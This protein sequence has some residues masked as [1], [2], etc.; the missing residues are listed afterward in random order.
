VQRWLTE[1]LF[2]TTK[3]LGKNTTSQIPKRGQNP[4][5]A[6]FQ[7]RRQKENSKTGRSSSKDKSPKRHTNGA[8][9]SG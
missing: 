6:K 5:R 9:P 7:Q 2:I 8:N 1:R 3:S 4:K